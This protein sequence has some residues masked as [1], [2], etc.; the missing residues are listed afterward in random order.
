MIC[1]ECGTDF[2][3]TCPTSPRESDLQQKLDEAREWISVDDRLPKEGVHIQ[4]YTP[5]IQYTGYFGGVNVG[6]VVNAPG[7][8]RPSRKIT[9]WKP[10]SEPPKTT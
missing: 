2:S 3:K 1:K 10:L 7:L 6:W 5:E 9:H 4:M 8:P